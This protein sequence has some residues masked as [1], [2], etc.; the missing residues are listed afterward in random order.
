[1]I[2]MCPRYG[3]MALG[4]INSLLSKAQKK[5]NLQIYLRVC[6]ISSNTLFLLQ[7]QQ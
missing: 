2:E 4:A 3:P 6:V 1:M 5:K 7:Y